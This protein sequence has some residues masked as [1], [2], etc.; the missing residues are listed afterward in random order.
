LPRFAF[1]F[2]FAVAVALASLLLVILSEAKNPRIL[3]LLFAFA[4]VFCPCFC[5]YLAFLIVI[6]EEPALSEIEWGICCCPCS[7]SPSHNRSGAPSTAHS[8]MGGCEPILHPLSRCPALHLLCCCLTSLLLVILS[9]AKNP[10]IC[11]CFL[12]LLFVFAFCFCFLLCFLLCFCF[13]AF[14]FAFT[15]AS[16]PLLLPLGLERGFSP[17]STQTAKRAY[18]SAE[19]WSEATDYCLCFCLFFIFC[20][21]SPKN[22]CQAPKPPNSLKQN[23]IELAR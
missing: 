11:F 18:R 16:A 20:V 23:K 17:A 21:F 19:G 1:A 7:S 10:R 4:F 14:A 12:F 15:S 13:F 5:V 8:A 2:A 3:F 6:P 22:A 9:E